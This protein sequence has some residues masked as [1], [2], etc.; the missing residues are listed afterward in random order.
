MNA[1]QRLLREHCNVRLWV[2][3]VTSTRRAEHSNEPQECPF[4]ALRPL[5]RKPR[6]V[7]GAA[8]AVDGMA[9][10]F[11]QDGEVTQEL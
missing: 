5:A 7:L 10:T 8:R 6:H 9:V 11:T 3:R 1:T 4:M 2:L